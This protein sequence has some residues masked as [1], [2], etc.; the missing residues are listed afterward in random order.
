V[1]LPN[2]QGAC[3]SKLTKSRKKKQVLYEN[4]MNGGQG[5][6]FIQHNQGKQFL[7]DR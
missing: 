6:G 3:G 2:S 4:V 5:W 7:L 1:H